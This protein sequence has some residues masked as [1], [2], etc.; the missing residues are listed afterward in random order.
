VGVTAPAGFLEETR[1]R[2]FR[3]SAGHRI[4][5]AL[6]NSE[7]GIFKEECM[8]YTDAGEVIA[9]VVKKYNGKNK[10]KIEH[11][12]KG[13]TDK[14]T[15]SHIADDIVF[16]LDR[17]SNKGPIEITEDLKDITGFELEDIHNIVE[18]VRLLP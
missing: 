18:R 4:L 10:A 5:A 16:L 14:K 8:D 3:W 13:T 9:E 1:I 7:V 15:G 11:M 12:F 6:S 2:W 17:F